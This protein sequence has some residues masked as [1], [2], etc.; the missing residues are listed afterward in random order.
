MCPPLV[1][2]LKPLICELVGFPN[3]P[4]CGFG[5]EHEQGSTMLAKVAGFFGPGMSCGTRYAFHRV[6]MHLLIFSQ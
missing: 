3:A 2:I 6:C 4:R 5:F 1:P